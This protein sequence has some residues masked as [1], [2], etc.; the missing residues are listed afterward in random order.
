MWGFRVQMQ[1]RP[2]AFA[3]ELATNRAKLLPANDA[4]RAMANSSN[5]GDRD[6]LRKLL[7]RLADVHPK[8]MPD[9]IV[10]QWLDGDPEARQ[11]IEEEIDRMPKRN[12]PD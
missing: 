12:K 4:E 3:L 6:A 5:S 2:P 11:T 10:G 9:V 1:D 7:D 8:G